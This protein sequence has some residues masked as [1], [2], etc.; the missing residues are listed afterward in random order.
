[1]QILKKGGNAADAAIAITFALNVTE[2]AMSGIGGGMQIQ[3][4]L[5]GKTP[6]AINGSTISPK[7]TP[8][9][10]DKDS[11]KTYLRTT[12]PSTVRVMQYLYDNY[13]SKRLTWA[14]L[15][16][17]SVQLIERGFSWGDI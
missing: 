8:L 2:P 7:A 12:I 13:S 6:F 3:I 4:R 14:E 17:P 15:I 1:M 9:H 10:F 5:P 16:Q 11:L